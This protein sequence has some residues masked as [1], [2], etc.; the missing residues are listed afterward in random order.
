[1]ST[2]IAKIKAAEHRAVTLRFEAK[3]LVVVFRDGREVHV[4]LAFYPTLLR[5]SPA[6]RARW[7]MLGHGTAFHWRSLDLDLSVDGLIQGLREAIPVP[8]KLTARRS[9]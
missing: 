4:P 9:A 1:M 2:G 6:Q 8:P 7:E 3:R 5:A